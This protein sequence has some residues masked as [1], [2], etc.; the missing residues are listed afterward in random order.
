MDSSGLG[1]LHYT[2]LYNLPTLVPV[3]IARG[4]KVRPS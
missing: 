2:C 4:A 1:L 3:L